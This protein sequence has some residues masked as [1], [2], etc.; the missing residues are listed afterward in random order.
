VTATWPQF[1]DSGLVSER[2]G[3]C[4]Q[5]ARKTAHHEN[6]TVEDATGK[7]SISRQNPPK[8]I[9]NGTRW[10]TIIY[11]AL[12]VPPVWTTQLPQS[13]RNLHW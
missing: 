5:K 9:K 2:M 11:G 4:A 1:A 3:E 6:N 12:Q 8:Q 10:E 7:T 13:T